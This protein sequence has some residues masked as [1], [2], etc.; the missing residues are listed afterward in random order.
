MT[1]SL[2]VTQFMKY[3]T[4][5][6]CTSQSD[7]IGSLSNQTNTSDFRVKKYGRSIIPTS[8]RAVTITDRLRRINK[9]PLEVDK[10]LF[11]LRKTRRVF[12][13]VGNAFLNGLILGNC[14][15]I[16]GVPSNH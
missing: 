16:C 11:F 4:L 10:N 3:P 2:A 13:L 1:Y 8:F 5:G 15:K 7:L 12:V 9:I 14:L 6:F